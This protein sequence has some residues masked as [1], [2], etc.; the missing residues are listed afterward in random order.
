MQLLQDG[1]NGQE[2]HEIDSVR[3][4]ISNEALSVIVGSYATSMDEDRRELKSDSPQDNAASPSDQLEEKES[5]KFWEEID[6]F[7]SNCGK[8]VNDPRV[9]LVVVILIG[10]NAIMM[11]VAT[12]EFVREDEHLDSIFE[13]IDLAFLIIFTSE[14][15]L[16]GVYHGWRLLLDGWL[17]FDLLVI[18]TSWI[19]A[20]VQIVRAFRIFRSLRLIT[21]IKVMKD[22]VVGTTTSQLPMLWTRTK[23]F[24]S[25][26]CC[27][28]SSLWSGASIICYWSD[29]G[30]DFLHFC[31]Y[32]YNPLRSSA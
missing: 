17:V 5:F 13:S 21:R 12:Y 28:I 29:V 6:Q 3:Q 18:V 9:Q 30:L 31:R 11:G 19:F 32:V 24:Y 8:L 23:I 2:F 15:F 4:E 14:I 26:F 20:G 27:S 22:L 10:I 16:Q 1:D 7:R 25:P